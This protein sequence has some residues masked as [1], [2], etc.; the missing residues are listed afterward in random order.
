ML[1]Y[2]WLQEDFIKTAAGVEK[3]LSPGDTKYLFI[4]TLM[5]NSFFPIFKWRENGDSFEI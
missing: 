2:K 1:I 3:V 5:F 4:G